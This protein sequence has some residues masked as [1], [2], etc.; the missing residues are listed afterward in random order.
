MLVRA[1]GIGV[2]DLQVL[3]VKQPYLEVLG[4]LR[5]MCLQ[6]VQWLQQQDAVWVHG[7]L[8][9]W[10][11]SAVRW[12]CV[13]YLGTDVCLWSQEGFEV[14]VRILQDMRAI[15]CLLGSCHVT[16]CTDEVFD[17]A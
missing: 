16:V 5:G 1:Y 7:C 13:A 8:R 11:W 17:G 12:C 9:A 4:H 3:A 14:C 15:A 6:P 2:G 10:W